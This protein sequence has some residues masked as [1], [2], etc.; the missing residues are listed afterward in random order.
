MRLEGVY[1]SLE[2]VEVVAFKSIFIF[3]VKS[4]WCSSSSPN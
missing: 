1:E 4:W 3:E 2:V